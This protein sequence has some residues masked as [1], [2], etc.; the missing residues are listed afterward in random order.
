MS[1]GKTQTEPRI[2]GVRPGFH[3]V[4][5]YILVRDASG[6]I[7]WYKKALG[8]KETLRVAAPDRAGKI[9][10]AEIQIG[11]ST[12]ML[13]DENLEMG[14]RGAESLGGSPVFLMIYTTDPDGMQKQAVAAGATLVRPIEEQDY[15]RAGSFRDPYGL[16]WYVS[17]YKEYKP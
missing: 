8:A 7:D 12:I 10:H 14:Y 9:M 4:T 15:G 2:T 6:A 1:D 3:S 13:S 5:P 17:T 11:D 16:L